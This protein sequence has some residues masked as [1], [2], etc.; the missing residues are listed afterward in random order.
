MR[1]ISLPSKNWLLYTRWN[2]ILNLWLRF[3]H[4]WVITYIHWTSR[5]DGAPVG[6][7][8]S[9]PPWFT[10]AKQNCLCASLHCLFKSVKWEW[11]GSDFLRP[12]YTNFITDLKKSA[13]WPANL[14]VVILWEI[15]IIITRVDFVLCGNPPE[16]NDEPNLIFFWKL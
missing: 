2:Q 14:V 9:L 8:S 15:I 10:H 13:T 6:G 5:V 7:A 4:N 11:W 3:I 16:P 12:T 1:P